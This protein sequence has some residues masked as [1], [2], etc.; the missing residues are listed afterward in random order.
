MRRKQNTTI[1]KILIGLIL[2]IFVALIIKTLDDKRIKDEQEAAEAA[3]HEIDFDK[4]ENVSGKYS[5][6][7]DYYTS[8]FG[9]DVS[10][11]QKDINWTKVKNDF[12]EFAYLRLGRRGA[13][14]GGLY[15][16]EYFER[17][18]EGAKANDLKVGV[19][20]FSQALDEKEAREEAQFVLET[21]NG[22]EVDLPIVFDCEEVFLEEGLLS[23][24]F[25]LDKN[26]LTKNAIAFM[27]E[28]KKNGYEAAVYT[29][30]YWLTNY[31]ILDDLKAY[32]IWYAQ[33]DVGYPELDCPIYIW[34]Y[35]NVG[36]IN[37]ITGDTDLNI[38]FIKKDVD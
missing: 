19:Y 24:I 15:V 35:S 13:T 2:F 32:P 4:I 10:E 30:P 34:Q 3:T 38:M 1:L 22:R 11:F 8:S 16:D 26:Q 33:Y 21:L 14:T 37:G 17:N 12:V 9:I 20:F 7:D 6:E 25:L 36:T 27:E 29:Y 5:Y 31:Y 23:R 18:Y 28:I